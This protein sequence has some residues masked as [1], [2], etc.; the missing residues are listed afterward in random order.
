MSSAPNDGEAPIDIVEYDS[1]WPARFADERA[2]I[3][4][5]IA[6]WLVGA[7][8]HIGSTAV[9]GMAAKPIIDIMAP[10]GTLAAARLAIGVLATIGY[11]YYPYK[12]DVM[13]WLCKP[14][15]A[16]RAHHLQLVPRDS[17]LWRERLAF[18]DALRG[19]VELAAE[20]AALKRGMAATFRHD[21]EAY[22][23]SKSSFIGRVLADCP[24]GASTTR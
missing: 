3:E 7:V 8:E 18:R 14:S 24:G 9:P 10:V 23:E 4:R 20:Y 15:L 5:T 21:R 11:L 2:L 22:T 17:S 19:S 13:H 1:S 12:A 16:F 6:P